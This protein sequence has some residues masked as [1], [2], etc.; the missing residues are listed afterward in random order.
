MTP[1][2]ETLNTEGA[3]GP[4]EAIH[5]RGINDGGSD[6]VSDGSGSGGHGSFSLTAFSRPKTK[7]HIT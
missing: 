4:P 6:A 2:Y 3:P 7:A 1:R 5:V